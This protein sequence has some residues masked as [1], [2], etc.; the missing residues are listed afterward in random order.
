[1]L[2]FSVEA[3]QDELGLLIKKGQS[4]LPRSASL[5]SPALY[6]NSLFNGLQSAGPQ[7]GVRPSGRRTQSLT[8]VSRP[9]SR[10][11]K[12][13]SSASGKALVCTRDNL[14]KPPLLFSLSP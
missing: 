13:E 2:S 10:P 8:W 11:P 14:K 6:R 5:D 3:A 4:I 1:M 12:E 7:S 9:T